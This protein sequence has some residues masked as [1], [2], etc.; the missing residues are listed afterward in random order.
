MLHPPLDHPLQLQQSADLP[1]AL[2]AD[3]RSTLTEMTL[4]AAS[5]EQRPTTELAAVLQVRGARA[6]FPIFFG[7]MVACLESD[8]EESCSE[9]SWSTDCED[10]E[11]EVRRIPGFLF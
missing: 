10:S 8:S 3:V 5:L 1:T 2:P 11:A 9:M 4:T 7:A 6:D